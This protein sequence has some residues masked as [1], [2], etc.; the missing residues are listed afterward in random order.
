MG[1]G[2]QEGWGESDDLHPPKMLFQTDTN[3]QHP[4][5]PTDLRS[6]P[7]KP[8]CSTVSGELPT[9]SYYVPVSVLMLTIP[10]YKSSWWLHTMI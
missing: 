7:S 4:C 2:G 3:Q 5:R 1:G 9:S 8:W 6:V 10:C